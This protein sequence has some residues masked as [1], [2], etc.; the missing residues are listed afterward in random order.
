LW[1]VDILLL[2]NT[3]SEVVVSILHPY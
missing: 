2:V 3:T 1:L